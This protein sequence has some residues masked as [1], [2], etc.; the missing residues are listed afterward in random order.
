MK[1]RTPNLSLRK[2]G[3][4]EY[5]NRYSNRYTEAVNFHK[6][7]TDQEV[8]AA[9]QMNREQRRKAQRENKKRNR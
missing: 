6:V 9:D 3:M 4:G 2:N 1:Y 7:V 8:F 5:S